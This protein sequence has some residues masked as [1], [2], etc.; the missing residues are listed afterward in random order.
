MRIVGKLAG[1]ADADHASRDADAFQFRQR[2]QIDQHFGRGQSQLH[3]RQQRLAAGNQS[4][5]G[6]GRGTDGVGQGGRLS[7][8]K[9]MHGKNSSRRA[10]PGRRGCG[11]GDGGWGRL[12]RPMRSVGRGKS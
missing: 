3:R 6:I 2:A 1:R 4:G 5:A 11:T 7:V 9:G 8:G 12:G 10:A